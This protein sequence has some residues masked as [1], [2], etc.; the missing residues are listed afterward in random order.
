MASRQ[1]QVAS[2]YPLC[3]NAYY[4]PQNRALGHQSGEPVKCLKA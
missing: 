1:P 4:I 3:R 2:G